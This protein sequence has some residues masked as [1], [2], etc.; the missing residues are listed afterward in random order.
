MSELLLGCGKSRLK[1]IHLGNP[2]WTDLTTL[3]LYPECEPDILWDLNL[4]P[5][6]LADN[7][8]DE[9]HAYEVLEHLGSQ[10]DYEAFFAHFHELWRILKPSGRLYASTP[11]LHSPWIWGDPGHRRVVSAESLTFLD[12][13]NYSQVGITAMT[14]YRTWWRGDFK[15]IVMETKGDN[16][17]FVLEARK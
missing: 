8:Y 6:P 10:G 2:E 12:Q 1:A 5:W 17:V 4:T 9:V 7:A 3:D 16:F 11:A 14:D 15:P 13:D